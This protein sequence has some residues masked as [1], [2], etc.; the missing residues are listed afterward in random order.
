MIKSRTLFK[1]IEPFMESPEAIIVSGMRR[2][3]KTT[4]LRYFHDRI[5]SGNKLFLDLENPLYRKYFE[6]GNYE[7]IRLTFEAL[8]LDFSKKSYLFLD[9]IQFVRNLPSVAKYLLDHYGVKFFLS[10]SAGFYLKNL[11]SETLSGRKYIFELYPLSFREFLDFKDSP[12]RIPDTTS[13]I[14]RSFFDTVSPLYEEYILYGGFPG[15]VLKMSTEE[16]KKALDEIFTSFFQQEV[17]QLGN[18]R[19][20]DVVRDLILLLAQRTGSKIDIQKLSIDL[21]VTRRTLYDYLAFLEGTYLIKTIRPFSRGRD[22]E[23][24]KMPKVYFC[25]SGLADRLARIDIGILFENSVFQNL[26]LKGKLNFYQRKTGVEIDFILDGT[27]AFEVKATP[28]EADIRRLKLL[29]EELGFKDWKVLSKNYC[30]LA[31]V[32]FG[33]ML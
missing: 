12:I 15:V 25:D 20:N 33:F 23:I 28:Q 8:G 16:K 3:G 4:L 22:S 29:A 10:G 27:A 26:R 9:E 5:D 32:I 17:I 13:A 7:R 30:S 21:G 6:E 1:A 18:F 19:K 11:F 14:S 24:R 31:D 2:T